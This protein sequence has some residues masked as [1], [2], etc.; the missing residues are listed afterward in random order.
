MATCRPAGKG[1]GAEK[2]RAPMEPAVWEKGPRGGG[3]RVR[4]QGVVCPLPQRPSRSCAARVTNFF[5]AGSTRE[6]VARVVPVEHRAGAA[7]WRRAVRLLG[8]SLRLCTNA[9]M[10]PNTAS[11]APQ[12]CR[13]GVHATRDGTRAH[14]TLSRRFVGAIGGIAGGEKTCGFDSHRQHGLPGVVSFALSSTSPAYA[15]FARDWRKRMTFPVPRG[16][17]QCRAQS[18]ISSRRFSNR[19]PRRYA[20][21][22]LSVTT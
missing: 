12:R 3:S 4:L 19:S 10:P 5:A 9:S 14:R 16:R 20:A 8:Y 1:P 13:N 2:K 21:S 18:C 17:P 6:N 7:V 11:A 15:D 22:V